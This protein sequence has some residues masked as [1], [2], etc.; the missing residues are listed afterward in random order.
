MKLLVIFLAVVSAQL[1]NEHF[2]KQAKMNCFPL[3]KTV[4]N[5]C[6][7]ADT[8]TNC[9]KVVLSKYIECVNVKYNEMVTKSE[10]TLEPKKSKAVLQT[11][12]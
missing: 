4:Y 12:K 3:F 10:N 11:K 8:Q 2:K 9:K 1:T 5:E 7:K 6:K